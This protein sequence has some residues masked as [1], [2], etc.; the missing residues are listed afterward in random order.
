[1]TILL[2][3]SNG[4]NSVNIEYIYTITMYHD[5]IIPPIY[6]LVFSPLAALVISEVTLILQKFDSS[7]VKQQYTH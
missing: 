1:M 3:H 6:R 7:I 2:L 4:Y 5:S